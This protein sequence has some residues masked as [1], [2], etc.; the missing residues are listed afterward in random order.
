MALLTSSVV[1]ALLVVGWIIIVGRFEALREVATLVLFLAFFWVAVQVNRIR[2]LGA[3]LKVSHRT[4]PALQTAIDSVRLR[5]DYTKRTDVYVTEQTSAPIRL[6]SLF[7]ARIL[8]VKGDFVADLLAENKEAEL[9]FLLA[10]YFGALKAKYDR[11]NLVLVVLNFVNV[12]KFVNPLLNPWYRATV[13]SGDQMAY[14]CC[15]DL[16][17]SLAVAFRSLVG[18]E[19]APLVLANGVLDQARSVRG[20]F[21]LRFSQLFAASPHPTNRYLNLL[22]FA[23]ADTSEQYDSFVRALE[24]DVA[25]YVESYRANHRVTGGSGALMPIADVLSGILLVLGVAVGAVL[26]HNRG[27]SE[28]APASQPVYPQP[29]PEPTPVPEPTPTPTETVSPAEDNTSFSTFVEA[30]PYGFARTCTDATS[31]MGSQFAGT[32]VVALC[33]PTA[34][35]TPSTVYIYE[36]DTGSA[37]GDAFDQFTAG[38]ATGNCPDDSPAVNTWDYG[39]DSGSIGCY[40]DSAGAAHVIWTDDGVGVLTDAAGEDTDTPQDVMDWWSQLPVLAP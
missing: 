16:H 12:L 37:A 28:P 26:A 33:Y 15:R 6:Q 7:G 10:T 38:A 11:L 36:F 35:G 31:D 5:L 29:T 3:A 22:A 9:V 8:V 40:T 4:T 17:V 19:M 14:V 27:I 32:E 21:I 25:H 24:P 39:G 20:S 1:L 18:K 30:L 2:L 23:A 34:P 13:Y